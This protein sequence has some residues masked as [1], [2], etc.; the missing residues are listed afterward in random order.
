MLLSENAVVTGKSQTELEYTFVGFIQNFHAIEQAATK[1]EEYS[2]WW[3]STDDKRN[4]GN[5]SGTFR[6][7]S[8]NNREFTM[9]IKERS[10]TTGKANSAKET[11]VPITKDM[12][13]SFKRLAPLGLNKTRYTIPIPKSRYVWEIDVFTNDLGNVYDWCKMDLEVRSE[14]DEIPA[15]PEGIGEMINTKERRYKDAVDQILGKPVIHNRDS[16]LPLQR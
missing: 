15:P 13:E 4:N 5:N 14:L 7:R 6:V 8:I 16:I 10:R 12:F 9:T 2:Q 3:M 1:V 11:E